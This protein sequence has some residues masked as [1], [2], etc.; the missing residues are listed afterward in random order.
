MNLLK[1][2]KSLLIQE[3]NEKKSLCKKY[4]SRAREGEGS[5]NGSRAHSQVG[6]EE[7]RSE[8]KIGKRSSVGRREVASNKGNRNGNNKNGLY[9]NQSSNF[10]I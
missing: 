3:L 1:E 2:E 4:Y 9:N 7:K 5:S 10:A 8:G 6:E